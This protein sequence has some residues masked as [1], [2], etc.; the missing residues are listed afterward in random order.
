MMIHSLFVPYGQG[1]GRSIREV[2]RL[3]ERCPHD[4]SPQSRETISVTLSRLKQKGL[5]ANRG[6]R[7]K[8]LWEITSA[9]KRH[10]GS[11]GVRGANALPPK[12]GK[13]RLVVFDI[14][15]DEREK[16]SWLRRRLLA[17]DFTPLQKSVWV[18]KRMLPKELLRELKDLRISR[19]IHVFGLEE[20]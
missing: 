13:V 7:N 20:N 19:Y 8:T 17:C 3:A 16:R 14:P 6:P 11:A 10:F 15:E 2:E 12:D 9:G 4:L 5:V 1:L 18:G